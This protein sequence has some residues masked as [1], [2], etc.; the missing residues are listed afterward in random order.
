MPKIVDHEER[1][2][3]ISR[4]ILRAI[5]KQGLDNIT[6]RGISKEGG[7][8]SGALAHYFTN[9]EEMVNF[10]FSAIAE[11]AYI[12]IDAKLAKCKT[13]LKKV[14]VIIEEHLPEAAGDTEAAASFAA[15]CLAFWGSAMHDAQLAERFREI[16]DRWRSYLTRYIE[17]AIEQGEIATIENIRDQVDMMIAMTDGLLVSFTINPAHFPKARRDRLVQ[18]VLAGLTEHKPSQMRSVV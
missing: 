12:R 18:A 4:V 6:I 14:R 1:R 7:F 8:S 10:A 17:E 5:A 3:E 2:A 13:A 11:D 9:K 15:I 16:Y